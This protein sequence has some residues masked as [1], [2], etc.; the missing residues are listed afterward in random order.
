MV[1]AIDDICRQHPDDVVAVVSHA[2]PIK[3]AIAYYLGLD[4]DQYQRL[5][6]SPTSVTRSPWASM[7][8]RYSL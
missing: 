8:R 1:A 3:T 4:L 2:D 5:V 7:G 6:I